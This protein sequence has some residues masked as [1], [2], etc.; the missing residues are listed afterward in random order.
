MGAEPVRPL[1]PVV[2]YFRAWIVRAPA[3]HVKERIQATF[4]IVSIDRPRERK[5]RAAPQLYR[6]SQT[7]RSPTLP[8]AWVKPSVQPQK[9]RPQQES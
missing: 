3:P 4:G 2:N 8:K 6:P 7:D 1:E 5:P 9:Q